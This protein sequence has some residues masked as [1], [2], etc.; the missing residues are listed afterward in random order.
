[1]SIEIKKAQERIQAAEKKLAKARTAL[2]DALKSE[3]TYSIG[4]R[5]KRDTSKYILVHTGNRDKQVILAGLVDGTCW[6]SG[7]NPQNQKK[8][9]TEEFGNICNTTYKSE[10]VRYWDARKGEQA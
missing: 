2:R 6:Y 7:E 9:T 1:M 10:F 3:V 5:F 8:I 4:D